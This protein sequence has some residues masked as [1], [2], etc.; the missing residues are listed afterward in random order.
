M[1]LLSGSTSQSH[2]RTNA[3]LQYRLPQL[4]MNHLMSLLFFILDKASGLSVVT[5]VQK[6]HCITTSVQKE[7]PCLDLI[8]RIWVESSTDAAAKPLLFVDFHRINSFLQVAKPPPKSE[9]DPDF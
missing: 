3:A 9:K 6:S 5:E 1:Q 4:L 8:K 2:Y 7:V